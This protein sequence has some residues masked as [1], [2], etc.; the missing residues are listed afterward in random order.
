MIEGVF[1]HCTEMAVDRQYVDSHGQ[2]EVAFPFCRFLGSQLLPRLKRIHKQRLYHPEAGRP[3]EYPNLRPVLTRPIDWELIRRQY[4]EMVKYTTAL[5][6]GTAG[7]EAL[8]RRFTRANV[9][10]RPKGARRARQGGEDGVLVPLPERAAAPAR[11]PRGAQRRRAVELGQRLRLLRAQGRAR[12]QPARGP[13]G[14]H[15]GAAPAAERDGLR[16]HADDPAHLGPARLGRPAHR[17]RSPRAHAA[18]LGA[19]QPLRPVRPRHDREIGPRL[20]EMAPS[21]TNLGSRP[22]LIG[23]F[24]RPTAFVLLQVLV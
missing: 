17:R 23:G 2:S 18:D 8:L 11:D 19:H 24:S 12:K 4:D 10:Y 15:A 22:S 7:T 20:S 3:D 14:Q 5:R 6:L 21:N 9:Q 1:R 13:R 16:Q